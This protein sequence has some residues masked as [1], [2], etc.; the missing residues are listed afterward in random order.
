MC[1]YELFD[2]SVYHP[3]LYHREVDLGHRYSYQWLHVR[4]SKRFPHHSLLAESLYG[5]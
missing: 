4:M 1:L 2:V 5:V 3:L